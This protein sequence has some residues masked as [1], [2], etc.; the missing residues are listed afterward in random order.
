MTPEEIEDRRRPYLRPA[1]MMRHAD[2]RAERIFDAA[3]G[4]AAARR[5]ALVGHRLIA[6]D[7]YVGS[8]AAQTAELLCKQ[9]RIGTN[10]GDVAAIVDLVARQRGVEDLELPIIRGCVRDLI[11]LYERALRSSLG[12]QRHGAF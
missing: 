6:I 9:E 1:Q 11:K 2:D 10:A 7:D 12:A 8:A 4:V 5:A 3:V